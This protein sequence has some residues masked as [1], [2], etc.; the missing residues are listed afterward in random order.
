MFDLVLNTSFICYAN[1]L[2]GF[3]LIRI[4]TENFFLNTLL[5]LDFNSTNSTKYVQTS[6]K[7]IYTKYDKISVFEKNPHENDQREKKS[8]VG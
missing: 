2:I 7:N 3:Y 5:N 6:R 8:G 1:Q 4:F